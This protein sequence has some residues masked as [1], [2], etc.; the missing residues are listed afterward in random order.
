[1]RYFYIDACYD[2]EEEEEEEAFK[3]AMNDLYS[4]IKSGNPRGL[5]TAKM[6]Q[7]GWVGMGFVNHAQLTYISITF[8]CRD[9]IP[10]CPALS[11]VEKEE[12]CILRILPTAFFLET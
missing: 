8:P 4:L 1:M 11:A 2:E 9:P 5:V 7:E 6:N 10:P 3:K 12:T